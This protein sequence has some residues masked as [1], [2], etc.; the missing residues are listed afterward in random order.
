MTLDIS[1][2]YNNYSRIE[3]FHIQLPD[4]STLSLKR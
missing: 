4:A 2:L 1:S 3:P